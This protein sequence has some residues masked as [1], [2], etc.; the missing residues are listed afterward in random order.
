PAS[1]PPAVG[2]HP[3]PRVHR[4]TS[5]PIPKSCRVPTASEPLKQSRPLELVTLDRSLQ[6]T[7]RQQV[8][9]SEPLERT[10]P[11]VDL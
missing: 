6:P 2:L 5:T 10:H 1:A 7:A 4:R 9:T 3:A 8:R 11:R